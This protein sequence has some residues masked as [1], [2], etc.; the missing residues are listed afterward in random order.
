MNA[1]YTDQDE[2]RGTLGAFVDRPT[3]LSFFYTRCENTQKSSATVTSLGSLERAL[4]AAGM[5]G[6]VRVLAICFEPQWDDSAP[7]KRFAR[8]RDMETG[9]CAKAV[10]LDEQ[11]QMRVI[12]E[13]HAP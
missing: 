9:D 7:L 5:R 1:A 10:R 11:F 12:D 2:A 4:T 8:D 6:R 13:L 3:V